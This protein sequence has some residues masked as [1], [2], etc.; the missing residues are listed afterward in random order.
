[1]SDC[2]TLSSLLN[3]TVKKIFW[4]GYASVKMKNNDYLTKLTCA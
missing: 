1:M 4:K 2:E 3:K